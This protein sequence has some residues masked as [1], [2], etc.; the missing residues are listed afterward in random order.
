M[1]IQNIPV[2]TSP[3]QQTSLPTHA[4]PAQVCR[5]GNRQHYSQHLPLYFNR[6]N[7]QYNIAIK[8]KVMNEQRSLFPRCNNNN[9]KICCKKFLFVVFLLMKKWKSEL[10][11]SLKTFTW[12]YNQTAVESEGH[13]HSVSVK[14]GNESYH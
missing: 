6:V 3:A 2:M 14:L 4:R 13:N 5:P 7:I 11:A 1:R 12:Q 9:I 10:S 8:V